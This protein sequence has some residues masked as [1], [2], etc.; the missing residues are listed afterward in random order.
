MAG[1]FQAVDLA[2]MHLLRKFERHIELSA[3]ER[4]V[5]AKAVSDIKVYGPHS[6]I[7]RESERVSAIHLIVDGFCC[8][9]KLLPDGRRQIISFVIPG[10]L[11]DPGVLMLD[12]MDH[13]I[14][15]FTPTIVGI[16]PRESILEIV[17]NFPRLAKIIWRDTAVDDAITREWLVNVGQRTALERLAHLLCELHVRTRPNDKTGQNQFNLPVTQAELG[18]A[19]GLSAVHINRTFQDLRAQGLIENSGKTYRIMDFDALANIAMFNPS[20]LQSSDYGRE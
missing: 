3:N 5:L 18:D 10:E 19:L 16:L 11:C 13:T 20:Y 12:R 4:N 1:K 6:D 8:R 9:Y 15:T 2:T 14:A 17:A 7:I